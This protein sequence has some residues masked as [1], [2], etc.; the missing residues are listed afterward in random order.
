MQLPVLTSFFATATKDNRISTLHICV[1]MALFQCWHIND[2]QNPVRVTRK[3]IMRIAKVRRTTYHKCMNDL[4]A[5][6]YIEY[7][8]SYHPVLGSAVCLHGLEP[9]K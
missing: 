6:G 2:F 1:Y 9:V 8:P 7:M 4:Q 5:F 3:Q